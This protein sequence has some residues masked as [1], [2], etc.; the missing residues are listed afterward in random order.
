VNGRASTCRTET[1][2][3][4]V[5]ANGAP[6]SDRPSKLQAHGESSRFSHDTFR[7]KPQFYPFQRFFGN[8][9][10]ATDLQGN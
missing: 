3:R 2:T 7:Q 8:L 5:R 9:R 4:A 6:R 10:Q 1:P